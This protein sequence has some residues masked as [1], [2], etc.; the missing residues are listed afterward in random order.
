MNKQSG[1]L[2]LAI[3][4]A[5]LGLT[6]CQRSAS[7][8]PF[9]TPT[10]TGVL[11]FPLPAN[12]NTQIAAVV[13]TQSAPTAETIPSDVP[14]VLQPTN[15]AVLVIPSATP[16]P[17]PT[18]TFVV[19]AT[20]TPGLPTTYTLHD[21]EWPYCIARRFNIDPSELL[22]ANKLTMEDKPAAGTELKIP[23]GANPWPG[24]RALIEHPGV[25]TAKEGDTIY[26]IACDYGDVDPNGIIAANNLK[27]PYTI[28]A[29]QTLQIP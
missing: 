15:T 1:L 22:S 20:A 18:P 16:L 6:G 2:I 7:K 5:I 19:V 12:E 13:N 8:A 26:S 4:I 14:V 11:P 27:S 28:T 21:G 9:S 10:S 24:P 29:G 17:Q 23:Q 3:M 25:Y